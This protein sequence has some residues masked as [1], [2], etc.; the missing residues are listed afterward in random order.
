MGKGGTKP[1]MD[2]SPAV[3]PDCSCTREDAGPCK[4]VVCSSL[5]V[6]GHW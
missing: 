2:A 4:L 3:I 5:S 6:K 1:A